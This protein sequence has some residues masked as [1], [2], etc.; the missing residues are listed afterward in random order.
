MH[1]PCHGEE[2][3]TCFALARLLLLLSACPVGE[4]GADQLPTASLLTENWVL[5]GSLGG[6]GRN[7]TYILFART[8]THLF[9]YYYTHFLLFHTARTHTYCY[10]TAATAAT[11]TCLLLCTIKIFIQKET[12]S[13]YLPPSHSREVNMAGRHARTSCLWS[14]PHSAVTRLVMGGTGSGL[15]VT[16]C[17]LR[18]PLIT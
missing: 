17:L 13:P 7:I 3:F 18:P 11:A 1:A 6:G 12:S 16:A 8:F 10:C 9:T 14:T 2:L 5:F 15:N 4:A